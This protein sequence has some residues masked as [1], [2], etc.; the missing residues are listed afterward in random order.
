MVSAVT[1]HFSYFD[2]WK[3][4]IRVWTMHKSGCEMDG[5]LHFWILEIQVRKHNPPL[6]KSILGRIHILSLDF[7]QIYHYLGFLGL[8]TFKNFQQFNI[9]KPTSTLFPLSFTLITQ[10]LSPNLPIETSD[11]SRFNFV[12][13]CWLTP[14]MFLQIANILPYIYKLPF[15]S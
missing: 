4:S 11:A 15:N 3:C 9:F 5:I 14:L 10:I 6:L 8:L 7:T 13:F 1:I 12:T 2:K